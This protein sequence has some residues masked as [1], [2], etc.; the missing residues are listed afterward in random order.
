MSRILM[1]ALAATLSMPVTPREAQQATADA[2]FIMK[3]AEAGMKEVEAARVAAEKASNSD[4]KMYARRLVVDHAIVNEELLK[5]SRSKNVTL[6]VALQTDPT[7]LLKAGQPTPVTPEGVAFDRAFIDQ[8]VQDHQQAIDL[9]KAE[10]DDG[11][12]RD[13]KE[14]AEKKLLTLK[15][16]LELAKDLQDKISR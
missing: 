14:W 12:D 10:A 7:E 1:F 5:L 2:D 6:K 16:H 8:M 3:A 11:K 4:V 9:F 15:A 13:V